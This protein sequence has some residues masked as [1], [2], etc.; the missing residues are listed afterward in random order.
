MPCRR[1]ALTAKL[2]EQTRRRLDVLG[3]T[4]SAYADIFPV[5]SGPQPASAA[6]DLRLLLVRER[7]QMLS[8]AGP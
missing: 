1:E 5:S 7:L 2:D 3:P 6:R 8:E 4:L